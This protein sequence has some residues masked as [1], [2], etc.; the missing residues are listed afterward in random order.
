MSNNIWEVPPQLWSSSA[1]VGRGS[2]NHSDAYRGDDIGNARITAFWI[3]Q[4]RVSIH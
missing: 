3:R 4:T 2:S 1:E